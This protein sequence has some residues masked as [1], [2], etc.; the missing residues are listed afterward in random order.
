MMTM[1]FHELM[2]FGLDVALAG[3]D[4]SHAE[5]VATVN[6]AGASRVWTVEDVHRMRAEGITTHW[7][8][9]VS[10]LFPGDEGAVALIARTCHTCACRD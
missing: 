7:I 2:V 1:S 8:D 5:L 4:M 3:A 9:D 10:R 6:A